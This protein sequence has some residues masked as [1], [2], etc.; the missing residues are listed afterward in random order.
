[1]MARMV[2]AY[3]K[4]FIYVFSLSESYASIGFRHGIEVYVWSTWE[5]WLFEGNV[6][7]PKLFSF[8]QSPQGVQ[9][10]P[11]HKMQLSHKVIIFPTMLSLSLFVEHLKRESRSVL[12]KT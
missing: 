10:A 1:M 8:F 12:R 11:W 9:N 4:L 2:D 5:I 6:L 3:E 7:L